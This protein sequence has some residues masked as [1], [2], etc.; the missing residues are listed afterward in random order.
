MLILGVVP[1]SLA[2]EFVHERDMGGTAEVIAAV[3]GGVG[4]PLF[5]LFVV[6]LGLWATTAALQRNEARR[7][8]V[9]LRGAA[10]TDAASLA[11][12]VAELERG[13]AGIPQ[14]KLGELEINLPGTDADQVVQLATQLLGDREINPQT[15]LEFLPQPEPGEESP[16]DRPPHGTA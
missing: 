7:A 12:R 9:Q 4:V 15:T 1:G 10:D 13:A 5:F 14:I 6:F 16:A 8:L 3:G 11:D 2:V